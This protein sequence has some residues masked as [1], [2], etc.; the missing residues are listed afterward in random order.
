MS[1]KKTKKSAIRT[2]IQKGKKG[3]IRRKSELSSNKVSSYITDA[4]F[5]ALK[6][7][8]KEQNVSQ[9][10]FIRKAIERAIKTHKERIR[11]A[12]KKQQNTTLKKDSKKE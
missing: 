7:V 8:L 2:Q 11:R 6:A 12:K 9:A 5:E 3:F 1:K 4:E 10:E